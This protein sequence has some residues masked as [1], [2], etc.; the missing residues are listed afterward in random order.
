MKTTPTVNDEQL[1]Q[2]IKFQHRNCCSVCSKKLADN[3][4]FYF[5]W[6]AKGNPVAVGECHADRVG[7]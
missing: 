3:S 5:G 7:G 1:F 4:Y 2:N 6:D